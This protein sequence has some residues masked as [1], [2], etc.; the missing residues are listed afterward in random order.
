MHYSLEMC[1]VP[2]VLP[3]HDAFKCED[4]TRQLTAVPAVLKLPS[5]KH[6]QI[7]IENPSP[8]RCLC[9][10]SW[11]G[12]IHKAAALHW[13]CAVLVHWLAT[14]YTLAKLRRG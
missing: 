8:K 13:L 9:L 6:F 14:S 2:K 4:D 11:N 7:K 5:K 12:D 1:S 10:T 3:Q